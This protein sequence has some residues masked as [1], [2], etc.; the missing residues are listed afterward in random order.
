LNYLG[1][2]S[3]TDTDFFSVSVHEFINLLI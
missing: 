3:I 1:V 2:A